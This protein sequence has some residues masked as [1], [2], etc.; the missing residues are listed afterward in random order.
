[1]TVQR[2]EERHFVVAARARRA[3]AEVPV[4]LASTASSFDQLH[5]LAIEVE[6][7]ADRVR[8]R[9]RR[10]VARPPRAAAAPATATSPS[11]DAAPQAD[12]P[13]APSAPAGTDLRAVPPGRGAPALQVQA[14]PVPADERLALNLAAT[15]VADT[16]G[17]LRLFGVTLGLRLRATRRLDLRLAA[18]LL[19]AED[20]ASQGGAKLDVI[21]LAAGVAVAIPRVPS[22][23]LGAG[24]EALRVG[25]ARDGREAPRYWALGPNL[26]L[27][28]RYTTRNLALIS[29]VQAALHPASWTTAGNLEPF[30]RYS[31]WTIG[32]SLGL[33]FTIF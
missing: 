3:V 27:E 28:H 13:P 19:H 31:A 10:R 6:L 23:R 11:N 21:P 2:H 25:G 8:P 17:E 12:A 4:E 30:V 32:G 9:K 14:P 16:A 24:V 26:R 29:A 7:L 5:A 15:A 33:E 18:G 1:V 20:I 22:L